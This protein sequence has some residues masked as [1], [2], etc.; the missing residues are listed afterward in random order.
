MMMM[1]NL[2]D[3][4]KFSYLCTTAQ[5]LAWIL[6]DLS[7]LESNSV[8]SSTTAEQS[9]SGPHERISLIGQTTATTTLNTTL[10]NCKPQWTTYCGG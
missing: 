10:V 3:T 8:A 7:K 6:I 1:S 9:K 4:L 5:L 2:C